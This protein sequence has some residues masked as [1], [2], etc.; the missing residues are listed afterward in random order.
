MS[1]KI[2]FIFVMVFWSSLLEFSFLWAS[3]SR[4]E[5]HVLL[6]E[7]GFDHERV[8]EEGGSTK[9]K[10][11]LALLTLKLAN[12]GGIFYLLSRNYNAS[13]NIHRYASHPKE[14]LTLGQV[15]AFIVTCLFFQCPAVQGDITLFFTQPR[16]F[17]DFFSIATD[18]IAFFMI[19][20]TQFIPYKNWQ[21]ERCHNDKS[22][23]EL[24][25]RCLLYS[26]GA[27]ALCVLGLSLS[28]SQ[29]ILH[30]R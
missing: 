5:S 24:L 23:E 9:I 17:F 16:T 1:R 7:E 25:S 22:C 2:F 26:Q 15:Q 3:S 4:D 13:F 8:E 27:M 6:L 14:G 30:Q 21:E 11:R 29:K 18:A 19:L 12:R 10:N 20:G 28:Y